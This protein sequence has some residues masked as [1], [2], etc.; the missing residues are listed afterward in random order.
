MSGVDS[1]SVVYFPVGCGRALVSL[2]SPGVWFLT[3]KG[4]DS[5]REQRWLQC[6]FCQER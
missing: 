1:P 6:V 3:R 4:V 2:I 5:E